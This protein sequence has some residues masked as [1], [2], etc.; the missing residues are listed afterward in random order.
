MGY[1]LRVTGC[2]LRV[3]GFGFWVAGYGLRVTGFGLRVLGWYS[4]L[5]SKLS[6]G[7]QLI[8]WNTDE[9]DTTDKHR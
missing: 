1:G 6:S 8:L 5:N 3:A 7:Q 9:T 4:T 2:E